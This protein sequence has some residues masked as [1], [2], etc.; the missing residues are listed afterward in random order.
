[1]VIG[2]FHIAGSVVALLLCPCLAVACSSREPSDSSAATT[3]AAAQ[4]ARAPEA[5]AQ[6]DGAQAPRPTPSPRVPP[7][8]EQGAKTSP[9]F[10]SFAVYAL[11]RAKGV[12]PEAREA[13]RKVRELL[14]VDKKRGL[15]V[16]V[17]TKRLG[18]EGE[19]RVCCEYD[20]PKA[21]GRAFNQASELV[22]GVDLVNLVV[23]PCDKPEGAK[24]EEVKP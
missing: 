21:A 13:L 11:S 1:M 4:G 9:V 14:E 20:D 15:G 12:P 16:R 7:P 24:K 17:E 2:R 6:P 3:G 10:K 19:T 8:P 22:K 18:I 5:S 23:E